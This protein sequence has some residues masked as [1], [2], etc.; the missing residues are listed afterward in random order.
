MD[1][2][3]QLGPKKPVGHHLLYCNIRSGVFIMETMFEQPRHS[4]WR[5]PR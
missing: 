1:I 4:P 3:E 5:S 2:I